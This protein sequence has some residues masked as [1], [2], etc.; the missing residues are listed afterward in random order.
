MDE[1]SIEVSELEE[2]LDLPK[3]FYLGLLKEDD[4]SFVIKLSAVFEAAGTQALAA[5]L[6][7]KEIEDSFAQ[8]DQAHP[9]YGKVALMY[10]LNIINQEQQK[11]LL[12]LAELRNKLVHNIAEISFN[13]EH[14]MSDF[15]SNQRKSIAIIFGHG[16]HETFQI[17]GVSCNRTDFTIENPKWVIWLT[18]NEILAC[19]NAE[20]KHGHNMKKIHDLGFSLVEKLTSGLN[21]TKT[22]G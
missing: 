13:L 16:I 7:H 20:I 19:I 18:A 4:W 22:S 2:L 10:K 11:F 6:Q 21:G 3:N 9:K 15:D 17:Q 5:K 1:M 14:Y 8:L 12:K